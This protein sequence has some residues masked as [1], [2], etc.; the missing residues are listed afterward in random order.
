MHKPKTLQIKCFQND[1]YVPIKR[2][3]TRDQE[4]HGNLTP[5]FFGEHVRHVFQNRILRPQLEHLQFLSKLGIAWAVNEAIIAP[6]FFHCLKTWQKLR[7]AVITSSPFSYPKLS[8]IPTRRLV[9]VLP[10]IITHF[11]VNN[12]FY[13]GIVICMTLSIC[14]LGP[15]SMFCLSLFFKS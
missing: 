15:Q 1:V 4:I 11:K 13:E 6:K 9:T 14:K 3:N 7:L 2:S 5:T 12:S 10:W 8:W